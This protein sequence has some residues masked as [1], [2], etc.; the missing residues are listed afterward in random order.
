MR[1]VAFFALLISLGAAGWAGQ[2]LWQEMQVSYDPVSART[3]SAREAEPQPP[4]QAMPPRAWP[5]LFGEKMPPL[6]PQPPEPPQAEEAKPPSPNAPPL[7]SLGYTLSGV[8][9]ADGAVW[10]LV[11]HPT[12]DQ[13]LRVGDD[14]GAGV[15]VAR[16]DEQGL[17]AGAEGDEPA[18]LGFPE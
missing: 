12:G 17:W 16:I 1:F 4:A 5:I 3:E 2:M 9:R 6:P 8:V 13:V 11:S 7:D 15:I 10:A 18:L 14:L